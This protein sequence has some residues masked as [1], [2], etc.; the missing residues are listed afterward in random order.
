VPDDP[1]DVGVVFEEALEEL[2]QRLGVGA[3]IPWVA[4]R[5]GLSLKLA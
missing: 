1:I 4:E 3:A 5:E 2:E